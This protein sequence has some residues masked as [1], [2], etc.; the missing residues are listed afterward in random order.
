MKRI[1]PIIALLLL[2]STADAQLFRRFAPVQSGCANGQCAAPQSVTVTQA[3]PAAQS[4]QVSTKLPAGIVY[5]PHD[6]LDEILAKLAA[7]PEWGHTVKVLRAQLVDWKSEKLVAVD[8]ES[9]DSW[10]RVAAVKEL[11]MRSIEAKSFAGGL[12]SHLKG[13]E[14]LSFSERRLL[15]IL[16]EPDSPRRDRQIARMERFA[17]AELNQ[18]SG[19]ID[20]TAIDWGAILRLLL[21]LL[22]LF[23]G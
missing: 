8:A 11:P 4:A 6:E 10:Q 18:P 20:W 23:L 21:T 15:R 17:R 14:S 7:K 9:F 16:N 2:A 5:V 1:F 22:P 3:A 12:Q 13:K 19:A